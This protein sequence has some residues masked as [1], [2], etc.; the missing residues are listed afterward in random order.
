MPDDNAIDRYYPESLI[1]TYFNWC[2][3]NDHKP[4]FD[5]LNKFVAEIL[6]D[7]HIN[8]IPSFRTIKEIF[9]ES[10]E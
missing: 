1:K 10:F 7:K 4:A 2:A 5:D 8:F 6:G 3:A 9:D